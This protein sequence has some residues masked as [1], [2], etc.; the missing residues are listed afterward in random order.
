MVWIVLAICLILFGLGIGLIGLSVNML[1][2]S[3]V[4]GIMLLAGI[5]MLIS[6]RRQSRYW[7]RNTGE[8]N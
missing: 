6:I 4:G 5:W 8:P 7:G 1:G 2:Y 3:I